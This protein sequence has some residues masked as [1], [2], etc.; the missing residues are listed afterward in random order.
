MFL[1]FKLFKIQFIPHTKDAGVF[2]Y[3]S[4]KCKYR[5]YIIKRIKH[6]IL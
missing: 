5:T 1:I 2:L 4:Y 3:L 6:D